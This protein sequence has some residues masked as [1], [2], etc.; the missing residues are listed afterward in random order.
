[1]GGVGFVV[2]AVGRGLVLGNG[3]VVVVVVEVERVV[4]VGS[5]QFTP[6]ETHLSACRTAASQRTPW[7]SRRP[8]MR[9]INELL[10]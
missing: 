10:N 1:M 9:I 3:V 8:C 7:A 4:V 6:V 2:G 5:V